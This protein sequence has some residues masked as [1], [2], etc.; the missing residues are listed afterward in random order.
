MLAFNDIYRML[1]AIAVVLIPS[2]ILFRGAK[3]MPPGAAS[4]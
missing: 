3:S 2:F 4:H 1:V